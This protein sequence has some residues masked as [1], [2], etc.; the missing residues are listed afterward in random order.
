[1][2]II[3][4]AK[5]LDSAVSSAKISDDTVV[6]ADIDE[7]RAYN[8]SNTSSTYTGTRADIATA[9]VNTFSGTTISATTIGVKTVGGANQFSG[10][11]SFHSGET[12][13]VVPNTAVTDSCQIFYGFD[14]NTHESGTTIAFYTSARSAGTSFTIS[15][16]SAPSSDIV[17]NYLIIQ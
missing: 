6:P 13:T 1:M 3:T 5:L 17:I 15:A 14:T 10:S 9:N 8:W 16:S 11:S 12:S 2:G 4:R 7:T